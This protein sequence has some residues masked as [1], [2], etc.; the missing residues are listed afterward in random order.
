[1]PE[2]TVGITNEVLA[3]RLEGVSHLINEKFTTNEVSHEAILVQVK[4]T[5]GTVIINTK[6]I[7]DIEDWKNK[8]IGALVMTNLILLPV[9]F[10]IISNWFNK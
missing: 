5:N 3:E 8:I 4:K 1:M 7:S 9:L 10:I 6:R 2:V